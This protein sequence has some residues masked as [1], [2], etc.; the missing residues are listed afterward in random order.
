MFSA[1]LLPRPVSSFEPYREIDNSVPSVI[2]LPSSVREMAFV[3]GSMVSILLASKKLF[4]TEDLM[5][6]LMLSGI[7]PNS[8]N[9]TCK[10]SLATATPT[11]FPALAHVWL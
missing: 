9:E 7:A 1:V 2:F 11:T 5:P 6:K 8:S 3:D 10:S 4:S